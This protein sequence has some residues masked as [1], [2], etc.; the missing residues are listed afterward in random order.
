[1]ERKWY[2]DLNKDLLERTTNGKLHDWTEELGDRP[3]N[4]MIVKASCR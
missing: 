1:M 3:S 2:R 4:W